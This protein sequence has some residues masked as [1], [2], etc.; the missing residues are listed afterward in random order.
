MSQSLKPSPE[1]EKGPVGVPRPRADLEDELWTDCG[2]VKDIP[3]LADFPATTQAIIHKYRDMFK[4]S[5]SK[6]RKIKC[7]P[8][9][10]E[11]NPNI[12]IPLPA[13]KCRP[14]PIH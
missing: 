10:L 7:E 4:T 6:A 11:L 13:T 2:E 3:N 12:P 8:V 9:H 5:L 1:V 14:V